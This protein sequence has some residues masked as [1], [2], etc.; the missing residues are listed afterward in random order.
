[1]RGM[2]HVKASWTFFMSIAD[3]DEDWKQAAGSLDVLKSWLRHSKELT[4]RCWQQWV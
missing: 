4:S 3:F 1:M 2:F